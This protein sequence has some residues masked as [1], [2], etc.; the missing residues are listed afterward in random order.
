VSSLISFGAVL[1]GGLRALQSLLVFMSAPASGF[2]AISGAVVGA[3]SEVVV[4]GL[5]GLT[6]SAVVRALGAWAAS[7]ASIVRIPSPEAL[8]PIETPTRPPTPSSDVVSQSG[9]VVQLADVRRL[10]RDQE[11]DAA[12]DAVRAFRDDHPG[13][14]RSA[15]A[16]DELERAMQAALVRLETELQAAREVNDPDQV[17]E[18]HGRMGPL[19]DEDRRRSLDVDLSHWFLAVVHRRLRSGRIQADVVELADRIAVNFGHTTDGASLRAS[20]PTLRRSA[21]LC[22][23]CGK[24]YTGMAAACPECLKP[25]PAPPPVL[26]PDELDEPLVEPREPRLFVDPFD[27]SPG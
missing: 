22:P 2:A 6:A 19:L 11:W 16:S 24:P 17:L 9:A 14:P 27:E 23:R 15:A 18:I 13:D 4:Y 20:M 12:T 3:C 26:E 21:G 5:V 7:Q 8:A 10:I 25:A 1:L